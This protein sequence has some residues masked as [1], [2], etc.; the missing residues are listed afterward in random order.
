MIQDIL[1]KQQA[2]YVAGNTLDTRSRRAMLQ[3]LANT[4]KDAAADDPDTPGILAGIAD[5]RKHLYK[6]SGTGRLRLLLSLFARPSGKGPIPLGNVLINAGTARSLKEILQPLVCAL[7]AGDT[8]VVLLPDSPAGDTVRK[9]VDDTF[10]EDFV[11]TV[12]S[13]TED[14]AGLDGNGFSFVY[15]C[16]SGLPAFGHEGFLAFSTASSE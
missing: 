3:I 16:G 12:P 15:T 9:I 11:A 4:I 6:W 2:F 10:T 5:I 8:A 14:G 7:S 13:G 1:E